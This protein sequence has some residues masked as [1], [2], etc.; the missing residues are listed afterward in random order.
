MRRS[1]WVSVALGLGLLCSCTTSTPSP[2]SGRPTRATTTTTP[3]PAPTATVEAQRL[4]R[5]KGGRTFAVRCAGAGRADVMLISG[6]GTPMDEGWAKVQPAI[7]GFAR[8][9]AYDRLGMGN[10]DSPPERQTFADIAADLDRVITGLGLRRPLV[11]VAHSLG[12]PIAMTWAATHPRDA[13]GVLLLDIPG[14]VS[15]TELARALKAAPFSLEIRAIQADSER[16]GNPASN[17]ESLDPASWRDL[18][19]LPRLGSVPVV[20]LMRGKDYPAPEGLDLT[21]F[22][23]AAREDQRRWAAMSD[24]GKVVVAE[25]SGHAIQV[26]RPDLVVEHVRALVD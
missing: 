15:E 5:V 23:A 13:K 6:Y 8:V 3:T 22:E 16:F 26:D 11:V 12:G 24:V 17:L 14:V 25:G 2:D 10:S 19:A 18:A 7:G 9:C 21:R 1:R 4:L 20:A